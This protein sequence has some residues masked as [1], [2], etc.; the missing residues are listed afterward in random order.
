L[1]K[2]IGKCANC[3]VRRHQ[4]SHEFSRVQHML[5]LYVIDT[6]IYQNRFTISAYN[7]PTVNYT[8]RYDRWVNGFLLCFH[9]AGSDHDKPTILEPSPVQ[10][11]VPRWQVVN[12]GASLSRKQVLPQSQAAESFCSHR[13]CD[14]LFQHRI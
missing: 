10:N 9:K 11:S 2:H 6:R 14:F 4:N 8:Q 1:Y 5:H 3:K 7:T 12:T 13:A